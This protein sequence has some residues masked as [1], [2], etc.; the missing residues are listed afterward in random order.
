MDSGPC[1]QVLFVQHPVVVFYGLGMQR[2][3]PHEYINIDFEPGAQYNY[4]MGVGFA[5][6]ER[7]TLSTR[8]FGSYVEEIEANGQRV[9]GTNTEPMTIRMSATISKPCNRLVEPFV[10]F[11]INDDSVNSNVGITWTF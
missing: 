6:N 1:G 9:P 3:F 10:E 7:I 8:F 11:G 5:V 4:L 2:S